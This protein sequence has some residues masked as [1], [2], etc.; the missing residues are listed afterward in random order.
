MIQVLLGLLAGSLLIALT[1]TVQAKFI[2][3]SL[4][5]ALR[6]NLMILPIIYIANTL[7]NVSFTKGQ[8]SFGSLAV[9]VGTQVGIYMTCL[10]IFSAFLLHQYPSW[11]TLFGVALLVAGA[12]VL[13]R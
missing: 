7:L 13:N 10:V 11:N 5:P 2:E 3:P 6:Y 8:G 9:V 12:I 4:W 1:V